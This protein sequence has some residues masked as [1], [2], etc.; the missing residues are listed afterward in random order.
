MSRH[1]H[2]IEHLLRPVWTAS[3]EALAASSAAVDDAFGHLAGKTIRRVRPL[4][5]SEL[6]D[7]DW[8]ISRSA[9]GWVI[10]FTDRTLLIPTA[11]PEGNGPGWAWAA[12]GI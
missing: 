12:T 6:A 7:L 4:N 1:L 5:V 10:E 2:D 9:P 3:T 11:D 8:P